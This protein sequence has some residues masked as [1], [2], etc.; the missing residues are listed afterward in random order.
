MSNFMVVYNFAIP[1]EVIRYNLE[2]DPELL[3]L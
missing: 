3:Y 2:M 1:H